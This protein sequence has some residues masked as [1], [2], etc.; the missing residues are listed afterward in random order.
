MKA[1]IRIVKLDRNLEKYININGQPIAKGR[2]ATQGNSH[3]NRVNS[4]LLL[5]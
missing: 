2:E 5:L 1:I 3:V 4:T